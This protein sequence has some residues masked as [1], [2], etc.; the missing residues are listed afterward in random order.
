MVIVIE[1]RK[2]LRD[3]LMSSDPRARQPVKE[4]LDAY[5][6]VLRQLERKRWAAGEADREC[7][8]RDAKADA[9]EPQLWTSNPDA[10]AV[11]T[12]ALSVPVL[13]Y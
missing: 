7:G 12:Q 8:R 3:W 1:F 13:T 10:Q 6:L 11:T 4:A 9:C 5:S 2:M